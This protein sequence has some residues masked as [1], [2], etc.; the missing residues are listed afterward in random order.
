MSN[1]KRY[2]K[3]I[4]LKQKDLANGA[5][6]KVGIHKQK[7]L[8]DIESIPAN[9][10]GYINLDITARREVSQYGETHSC[11]LDTWKPK[12]NRDDSGL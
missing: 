1:E 3:G 5:I 6:L 7:F 11:A 4:S 8:D 10:K 12:A 2:I 9:E